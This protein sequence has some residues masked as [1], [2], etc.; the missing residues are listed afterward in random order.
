MKTLRLTKLEQL[1]LRCGSYGGIPKHKLDAARARA[2]KKLADPRNII[3]HNFA[4][5]TLAGIGKTFRHSINYRKSGD[6]V[7]KAYAKWRDERKDE[8]HHAVSFVA[9][10]NAARAQ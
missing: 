8:T 7:V 5:P 3:C 2:L 9:G 6:D 10:F 4:F 1:A